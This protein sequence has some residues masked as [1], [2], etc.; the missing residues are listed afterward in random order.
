MSA[1]PFVIACAWDC[2]GTI[3]VPPASPVQRAREY[4]KGTRSLTRQGDTTKMCV[5][6]G[7]LLQWRVCHKVG[8]STKGVCR[9]STQS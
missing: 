3:R 7:R 8:I 9:N 6:K 1:N 2:V 4:S 5:S